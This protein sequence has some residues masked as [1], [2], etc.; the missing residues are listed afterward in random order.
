MTFKLIALNGPPRSG[1]DTVA[2]ALMR[3]GAD[4]GKSHR[5][6]H[7]KFADALKDTVHYFL[8]YGYKEED[9]ENVSLYGGS[10]HRQLYIGLSEL[11]AKPLLGDGIFGRIFTERALQWSNSSSKQCIFI[12]SDSG[13]ASEFDVVSREIGRDNCIVAE[14]HREGYT[15]D[16]DSRSYWCENPD[17]RLMNT[18]DLAV[19]EQRS[20]ASIKQLMVAKGWIREEP[21][22]TKV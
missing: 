7:R 15:F 13:F 18:S 14:V 12:A 17:L 9:K 22:G 19:F 6:M 11:W 1:K 10:T 16:G 21:T 3:N 5:F 2:H 4:F 8:G 20:V